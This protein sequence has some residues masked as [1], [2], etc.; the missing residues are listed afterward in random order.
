MSLAV[1]LC[2]AC[3]AT[4]LWPRHACVVCGGIAF[5]PGTIDGA[6]SVYAITLLH[7]SP[8]S[9]SEVTLP[10]AI[11]LIEL[12]GGGRLM[13]RVPNGLAIGDRV[14]ASRGD[15]TAMPEVSPI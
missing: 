4:A 2:A 11:A 9:G 6:A 8:T 3:G 7:R 14:H 15:V 1:N 10:Y 12:D 5:E 13:A